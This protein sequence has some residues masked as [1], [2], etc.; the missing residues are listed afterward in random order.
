MAGKVIGTEH[1]E[2]WLRQGLGELRAAFYTG[3]NIAQQPE[4]GLFGTKTAGEVASDRR[5]EL[6]P[7]PEAETTS[8]LTASLQQAKCRNLPDANP[9]PTIE[10]D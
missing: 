3:S 8:P 10:L 6:D 9:V 4:Q 1:A 7:A 5:I 2:A